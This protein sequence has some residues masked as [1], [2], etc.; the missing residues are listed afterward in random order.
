MAAGDITISNLDLAAEAARPATVLFADVSESTKLYETAGD[1]IAQ[2]AIGKCIEAMKRAAEATG[3]RVVKTIGDEVMAIFRMPD[4]A[5]AA[6]AEMQGTVDL[7]PIVAGT[8]LA[9]RIGF[10]GGPVIQK[11]NDVF[12][13]TVNLAARLVATAVKG[14]IITSSETAKLLGPMIRSSMRELYNIQVK[15]KAG[16]V[17]LCEMVWRRDDEDTTVF[18]SGRMKARS[19]NSV[20]RLKYHDKQITRRRDIESLDIGRDA[21]CGL[22]ITDNMASRRH[23]TIERRQDKWVLKDHSTN[24][25]YVTLEGDT[26]QLLQREELTLRK[27]GWIACGQT[28]AGTQEVVE[29]F[30]E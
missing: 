12:G 16:E 13:D 6:A 22:A 18:A 17:G 10:H 11:D 2:A 1:A 20:L 5:A 19:K 21:D 23:C 15:G 14:Q 30:V 25:T 24:G 28:R 27:H 4:A 9:L 7:M 29:F 3:G 8:K 26:E